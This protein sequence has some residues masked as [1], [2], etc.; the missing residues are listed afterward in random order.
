METGEIK[1]DKLLIVHDCGR[2]INPMTVEGQLE[3]G[4]ANGLGYALYEDLNINPRP[5]LWK[6]ITSTAISF[7]Q[8]STCRSW[9]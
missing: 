7:H 4:V 8:L 9:T 5:G 1:I 6:A 2:A 3:G